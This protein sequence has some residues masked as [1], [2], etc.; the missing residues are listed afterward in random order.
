[1]GIAATRFFFSF[2]SAAI[3]I[4]DG[5]DTWG[6]YKE[7]ERFLKVL[8]EFYDKPSYTSR[9]PGNFLEE[10]AYE[11]EVGRRGTFANDY[12]RGSKD[13]TD[14]PIVATLKLAVHSES[15]PDAIPFEDRKEFYERA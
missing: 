7:H 6:A 15:K 8:E 2:S 4:A 1:M 14:T 13:E 10:L 11:I 3:F 5:I 12:I 9:T